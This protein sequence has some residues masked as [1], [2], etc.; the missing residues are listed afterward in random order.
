[1]QDSSTKKKKSNAS[2]HQTSSKTK[3][4]AYHKCITNTSW[5]ETETI[6]K[7]Y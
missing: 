2:T 4:V 3:T 7:K 1:M 5:H 6:Q